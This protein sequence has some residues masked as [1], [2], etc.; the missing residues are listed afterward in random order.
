[1]LKDSRVPLESFPCLGFHN[2]CLLLLVSLCLIQRFLSFI[3]QQLVRE[4]HPLIVLYH[5]PLLLIKWVPPLPPAKLTLKSVFSEMPF[6]MNPFS[7]LPPPVCVPVTSVTLHGHPC[8]MHSV[9][10]RPKL[11]ESEKNICLS[12][13]HPAPSHEPRMCR[14]L[15]ISYTTY[16]IS[17]P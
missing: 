3:S 11:S 12:S 1:M 9:F 13:Q 15:T 5:F 6:V 2:L 7:Q 14:A 4:N 17:T 10:S 8:K 16:T